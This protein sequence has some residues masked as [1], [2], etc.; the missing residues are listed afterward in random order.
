[1]LEQPDIH[2]RTRKGWGWESDPQLEEGYFMSIL[3][4]VLV[5]VRPCSGVGHRD[6]VGRVRSARVLEHKTSDRN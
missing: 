6:I 3:K 5:W 2:R 1:M 4:P